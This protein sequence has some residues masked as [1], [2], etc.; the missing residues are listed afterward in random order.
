MLE[1]FEIYYTRKLLSVAHNRMDR[2][3]SLKF[4]GVKSAG[5]SVEHIST[6]NKDDCTFTVDSQSERGIKYLVDM[7][8]GVCSCTAGQDG[9]P[10]SHQA[11]VVKHYH[12]PA[13]NCIPTL[14]P[15]SRQFSRH[16]SWF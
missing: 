7:T 11:T 1:C 9:S 16:C 8:L 4:Q 6:L 10:C 2:Y 12:I 3:V 14:S 5:I 13:V 15:E